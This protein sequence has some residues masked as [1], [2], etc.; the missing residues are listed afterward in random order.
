MPSETKSEWLDFLNSN[1]PLL[2]FRWKALNFPSIG[3][4]SFNPKYIEKV[5]I[6]W[7][8]FEN[9]PI[10]MSGSNNYYSSVCDHDPITVTFYE[11]HRLTSVKYLFAWSELIFKDGYYGLP[12]GD[13]GYKKDIEFGIL[14]LDSDSIVA[15][16]KAIGAW[17][18]SIDDL[19]LNYQASERV[20]INATFTVDSIE[21]S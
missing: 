14:S 3:G 8:K 7:A 13:N 11:D 16:F 6:G 17:P 12:G 20:T 18:S 2:N 9:I 21:F 1:D 4:S 10:Y 19:D 15:R 5:N